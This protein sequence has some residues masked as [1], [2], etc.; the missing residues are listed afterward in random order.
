VNLPSHRGFEAA[1]LLEKIIDELG[2]WVDGGHK[3][4]LGWFRGAAL[5]MGG[6]M[7]LATE[8]DTRWHRSKGERK[9]VNRDGLASVTRA[10]RLRLSCSYSA[11]LDNLT[12]SL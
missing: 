8:D 11:S 12:G 3:R 6:R 4:N 10:H 9:P 5:L 1:Q 7:S 2:L